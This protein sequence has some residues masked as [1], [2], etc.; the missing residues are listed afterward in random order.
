MLCTI[1][2]QWRGRKRSR[3]DVSPDSATSNT[4][5]LRLRK[6]KKMFEFFDLSGVLF[7]LTNH[8]A[9]SATLIT[10]DL[11]LTCDEFSII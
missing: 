6:H 2:L 8:A 5:N 4:W 3:K 10:V 7:L 9:G 1:F 11:C